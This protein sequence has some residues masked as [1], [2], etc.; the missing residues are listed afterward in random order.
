MYALRDGLGVHVSEVPQSKKCGCQCGVCGG[1][2]VAYKGRKNAH[3][4][5]HLQLDGC[6]GGP[7]GP[8]TALH[9]YAIQLLARLDRL[10]L[11]GYSIPVPD[12]ARK[13][14]DGALLGII[15]APRT[16][17][18]TEAHVEPWLDGLCPDVLLRDAEGNSLHVEIVVTHG[19][20]ADKYR[21]L[22][23]RGLATL[24]VALTRADESL[25]PAELAAKLRDDLACKG[26]VFHP[27]EAAARTAVEDA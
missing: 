9:R 19:V 27:N 6:S 14:P 17:R 18:P 2:L 23:E 26:W 16:L 22:C 12:E 8:E 13:A 5:Q 4:F 7:G 3:H 20:D 11:P 15:T 1:V 24:V 10:R 21:K 25:T